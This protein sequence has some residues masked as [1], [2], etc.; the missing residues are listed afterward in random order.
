MGADE[1]LSVEQVADGSVLSAHHLHRY[2]IAAKLCGGR[3]VVDLGCG[4][5][6]GTALIARGGASAVEGVDIDAETIEQARG[7]YGGAGVEFTVGDAVDR[8]RRLDPEGV[9][10]VVAFEALEHLPRL[11]AALDRLAELAAQGVAMIL[12]VPNSRAFGERNEFHLTDFGYDEAKEAFARFEGATT[13]Y[14]HMAEG[15]VVHATDGST[16]AEVL[17]LEGADPEYANTFILVAGFPAEAISEVTTHLSAMVRASQNQ[18]MIGLERANAEL[19]RTNARLTR[20]LLGTSD[21][22]AAAL[23]ARHESQVRDLSAAIRQRDARIAELTEVA[24][25][26]D[27]LYQQELAWRDAARYHAVDWVRDRVLAVPG[28][29]RLARVAWA[30]L[31]AARRG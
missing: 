15:S 17:G 10:V 6:Y 11:E 8:L 3:R 26:N 14:Q 1:R 31:R 12:S 25:R 28:L 5:G 23:I 4:V 19:W 7:R 29:A 21:A 2:E 30:A 27:A 20:G 9:D 22:A 13:L 24:A 18:Y 16:R